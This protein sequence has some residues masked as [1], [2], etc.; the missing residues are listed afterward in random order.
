MT[1]FS[2]WVSA[3][4]PTQYTELALVLFTAVFVAVVVREMRT[5][6]KRSHAAWAALPLSDDDTAPRGGDL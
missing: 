6:R 5:S 1:R 3:L 4:T 2:E